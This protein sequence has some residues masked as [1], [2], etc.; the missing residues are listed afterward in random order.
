MKRYTYAQQ[1]AS[2]FIQ[3][4]ID[5]EQILRCYWIQ[6]KQRMVQALYRPNTSAFGR[7]EL[8]TEQNCI[9]DWVTTNWATEVK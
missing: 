8:I 9:D 4:T 5:E 6:W 2:N 7:P 1:T 3:I